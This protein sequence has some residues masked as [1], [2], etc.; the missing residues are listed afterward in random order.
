MNI[1]TF[2]ALAIV[3]AR[4]IAMRDSNKLGGASTLVHLKSVLTRLGA[5]QKEMEIFSSNGEAMEKQSLNANYD[6]IDRQTYHQI[7]SYDPEI[8]AASNEELQRKKRGSCAVIIGSKCIPPCQKFSGKAHRNC[9]SRE[10]RAHIMYY[11]LR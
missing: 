3:S 9:N 2:T 7:M 4:D 8:M 11:L 10:K 5:I 1:L 6:A